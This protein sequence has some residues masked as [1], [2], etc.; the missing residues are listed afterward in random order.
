ME[1]L[2]WDQKAAIYIKEEHIK[3]L[4]YI[5]MLIKKHNVNFIE[6][7]PMSLVVITSA[8]PDAITDKGNTLGNPGHSIF[9]GKMLG[10]PLIMDASGK[11]WIIL[12]GDENIKVTLTNIAFMKDI[13]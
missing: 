4:K 9:Y 2:I 3:F 13:E 12:H 5:N 6:I 8:D 11:D 7:T 1:Q 10:V